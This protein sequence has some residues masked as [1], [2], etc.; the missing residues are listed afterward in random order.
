VLHEG[1][2]P[3]CGTNGVTHVEGEHQLE[4]LLLSHA[5]SIVDAVECPLHI[6]AAIRS[7]PIQCEAINPDL[8]RC[9]DVFA[10]LLEVIGVRVVHHEMSE[11]DSGMG[12]V[13]P[14]QHREQNGKER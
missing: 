3:E 6:R 12:D 1:L 8:L 9:S 11:N 13:N 5:E 14:R 7:V 2:I 10:P 4:A